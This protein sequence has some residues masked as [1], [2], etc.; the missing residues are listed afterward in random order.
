MS[1]MI[2]ESANQFVQKTC[3]NLLNQRCNFGSHVK[4]FSRVYQ[5]FEFHKSKKSATQND[6][7]AK[8]KVK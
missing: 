7:F 6:N 4:N 8:K 2:S 3:W 5:F 1:Q